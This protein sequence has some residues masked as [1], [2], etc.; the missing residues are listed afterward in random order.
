MSDNIVYSVYVPRN[1][2]GMGFAEERGNFKRSIQ[3]DAIS[4]IF[5]EAAI[6]QVIVV[7]RY[8]GLIKAIR[9]G[10]NTELGYVDRFFHHLRTANYEHKLIY[11]NSDLWQPIET[12]HYQYYDVIN[13]RMINTD[14]FLQQHRRNIDEVIDLILDATRQYIK[15]RMDTQHRML[16]I[17]KDIDKYDPIEINYSAIIATTSDGAAY[18]KA[19]RSSIGIHKRVNNLLSRLVDEQNDIDIYLFN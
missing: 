14:L 12:M 5:D 11:S 10:Y 2:F 7:K 13:M 16:I 18:R 9:D 15:T 8:D 19:G 3:F 4:L 17:N 1:S 6:K